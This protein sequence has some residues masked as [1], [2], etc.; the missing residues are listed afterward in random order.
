M[1]KIE[2][3]VKQPDPKPEKEKEE[4][5]SSV[6][7]REFLVGSGAGIAGLVIGGVVGN[8]LIPTPEKEAEVPAAGGEPVVPEASTEVTGWGMEN[9]PYPGGKASIE[10]VE[11]LCVGCGICQIACSMHH[12]NVINKDLAR[13]QIRKYLLPLSKAVQTT[14]SYCPDEER[15]CQLAC[16]VKDGPAIYYDA[17]LKHMVVDTERCT[18]EQCEQCVEACPSGAIVRYIA[19]T[20]YPLVC[21]L[22]AEDGERTPS[23]IDVCPYNALRFRNNTPEDNWRMHAD[24]KAEL[25]SRRMYPLPKTEMGTGWRS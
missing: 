5:T 12:F 1:A 11:M 14:C 13:I 7:R 16:P 8:Q 17:D 24:D 25:I 20:P 4:S 15:E 6:S 9:Y 2:K 3:R 10:T 18:G 19:E 23:C 21:D 22:C